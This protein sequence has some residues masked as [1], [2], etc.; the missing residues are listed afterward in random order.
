LTEGAIRPTVKPG[1]NV[2][3][4]GL[5]LIPEGKLW[6]FFTLNGQLLGEFS[7]SEFKINNL[8]YIHN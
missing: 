6:I 4:C 3:G 8:M 2:Y 7:M 1:S 5:V